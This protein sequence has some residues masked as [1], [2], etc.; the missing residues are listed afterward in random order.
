MTLYFARSLRPVNDKSRIAGCLDRMG[1]PEKVLIQKDLQ[2]EVLE[3]L[4][5]RL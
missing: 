1:C 2:G 3:Y 4:Q 5:V